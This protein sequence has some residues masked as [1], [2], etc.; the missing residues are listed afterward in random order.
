MSPTTN[1]DEEATPLLRDQS[2]QVVSYQTTQ[3]TEGAAADVGESAE[4][5]KPRVSM[6]AV[7]RRCFTL[8]NWDA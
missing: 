4:V 5:L 3:P 1:H 8:S 7:V 2:S 6:A